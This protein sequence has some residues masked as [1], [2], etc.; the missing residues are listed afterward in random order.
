[1]RSF[2]SL[3]AFVAIACSA[4]AQE[5]LQSCSEAVV[6]YSAPQ[7]VPLKGHVAV[8]RLA[9]R[10]ALP[11]EDEEEGAEDKRWAP[12]H[13]AAFTRVTRPGLN[14]PDTVALEIFSVKTHA[15]WRM[16]F[17]R[18]LDSV[19][20]RWINDELIFVRA[21]WGRIV[22]TDLIFELGSGRFLY[23]REANY[24]PLTQPCAETKPR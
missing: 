9:V 6:R 14:G 8:K 17:N 4:Q 23:A 24:G 12:Q 20:A 11:P 16:D 1:M 18:E 22:S 5:A 2:I 21:W 19:E 10:P 3:L 7:L 13:T 15:R